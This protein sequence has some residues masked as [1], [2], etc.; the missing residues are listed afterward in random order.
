METR[1]G[2]GRRRNSEVAERDEEMLAT[3]FRLF[4]A[5][6]FHEVSLAAIAAEAKAAVRTIYSSFG[7]KIGVVRALVAIEA[8]RHAKQIAA[9][10][11]PQDC[12]SRLHV[13]AGH[14]MNRAQ[15]EA[16]L[17]L[18]VIVITTGH[19]LLSQECYAAGP[20]QFI[21]LLRVE[22]RHAQQ[23][24][25]LS[26]DASVDDLTDLFVAVVAG[27]QLK[28]YMICGESVSCGTT[29]LSTERPASKFLAL[30]RRGDNRQN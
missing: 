17:K 23:V 3:A 9:L 1:R 16:F 4:C 13:L 2:R 22:L 7:G 21:D 27:P 29:Q 25:V 15:D 30:A 20:G 18:H 12:E 8:T 19:H 10:A 28:R 24:G 6:G 11:L 14:L 26:A 5:S